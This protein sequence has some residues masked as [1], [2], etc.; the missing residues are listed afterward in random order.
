MRPTWKK[1]ENLAPLRLILGRLSLFFDQ[2][3]GAGSTTSSLELR[4]T[5]RAILIHRV[6][7]ELLLVSTRSGHHWP[8]HDPA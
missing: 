4:Q 5:L 6:V 7:L 1:L 2:L 8:G 3:G